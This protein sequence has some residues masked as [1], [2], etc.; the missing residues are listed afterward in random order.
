MVIN[1]NYKAQSLIEIVIAIGLASLVLTA[2]VV[3]GSASIKTST[4][5][6]RRAEASK[7][8][9]SGIEAIRYVRDTQGFS[10][11]A[12]SDG[13]VIEKCWIIRG[14]SVD[15]LEEDAGGC[16][17]N[18]TTPSELNDHIINGW[19][20]I[21]LEGSSDVLFERKIQTEQ[22]ANSD[23]M[24]KATSVVRWEESVGAV[25]DRDIDP[26]TDPP[27]EFREVVIS[28]VFTRWKN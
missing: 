5:S 17:A 20:I 21:A 25:P 18:D 6:L 15:L 14:T 24:V 9:S 1:Q 27:A 8:S 22:Y 3:L 13:E 23:D 19:D 2:L 28:T 4:S 12:D 10:N 26:D 11:F 16:A 7:L